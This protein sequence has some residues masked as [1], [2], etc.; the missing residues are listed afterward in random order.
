M[1]SVSA[2]RKKRFK[3]PSATL[4][5]ASKIKP[6]RQFQDVLDTVPA[7][8]HRVYIC[9]VLRGRNREAV[10]CKLSSP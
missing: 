3:A 4:P 7:S 1:H 8:H 5:N 2:M 6:I 9:L 10:V